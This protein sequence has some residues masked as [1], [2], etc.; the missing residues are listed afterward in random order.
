[1]QAPAALNIAN[2]K[3]RILDF[4]Q[5]FPWRQLLEHDEIPEGSATAITYRNTC[6]FQSFFCSQGG[7]GCEMQN[8]V[9]NDAFRRHRTVFRP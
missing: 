1:V 8:A 7:F 9:A 4:I 6:L 3:K 2:A 5:S